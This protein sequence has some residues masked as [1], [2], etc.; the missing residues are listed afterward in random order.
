MAGERWAVAARTVA[1]MPSRLYYR[2]LFR[3]DRKA[4]DVESGAEDR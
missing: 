1:R 3:R 2:R 4:C